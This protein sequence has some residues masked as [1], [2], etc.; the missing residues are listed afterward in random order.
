MKMRGKG[1]MGNEVNRN[2]RK[3][4]MGSSVGRRR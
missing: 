4:G 3:A 2:E 1:E